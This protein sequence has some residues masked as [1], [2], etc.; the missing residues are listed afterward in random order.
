[1]KNVFATSWLPA[2]KI[3]AN[4]LKVNF[5]LEEEEIKAAWSDLCADLI[6]VGIPTLL[7]VMSTGSEGQKV[8]RQLW[9]V[10]AKTWQVPD[11]KAHWEEL[12]S[13]LVIPLKSVFAFP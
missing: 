3:L 9:T 6:S 2:E 5:F 11:E 4:V 8:T 10:V 7:H 13:F 12:I 1:M